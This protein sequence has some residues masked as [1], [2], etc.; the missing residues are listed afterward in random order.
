MV[1]VV[2]PNCTGC[3][4][5][6]VC[7]SLCPVLG[8]IAYERNEYDYPFGRVRVV[9]ALCIGCGLC[10][11]RRYEA[12]V[13]DPER[14]E[15]CQDC[16][17]ECYFDAIGL[18]QP[19]PSG[20][21]RKFRKPKRLKAQVDPALCVGCGVCWPACAKT[22][23]LSLEPVNP[24]DYDPVQLEGCPRDAIALVPMGVPIS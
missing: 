6:P 16:V 11:T 7:L 4:G 1:A 15:G 2:S 9:P 14:C 19:E 8:A 5:F 23:A 24:E 10:V 13:I 21:G 18:V 12:A 20:T 22:G 17:E 3:S